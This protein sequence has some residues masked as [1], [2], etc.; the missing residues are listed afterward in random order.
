M[1]KRTIASGRMAMSA[2]IRW[3][4]LESA[5]VWVGLTLEEISKISLP[6]AKDLMPEVVLD[7]LVIEGCLLSGDLSFSNH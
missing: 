7:V 3:T 2:A 6:I 4:A 5:D 1:R